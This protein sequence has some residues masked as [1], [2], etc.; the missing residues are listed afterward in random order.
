MD[1]NRKRLVGLLTDDPQTVLPDGGQITEDTDGKVAGRPIG[2]ITST[3]FSPTLGHSIAM[4]LVEGGLDKLGERVAI[5]IASRKAVYA[6]VVQPK[7]LDP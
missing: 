7:F 6:K 5:P 2:H 4:A 1:P 3:Y